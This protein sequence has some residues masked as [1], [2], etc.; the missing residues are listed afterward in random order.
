LQPDPNDR[1][2]SRNTS[3]VILSNNTRNSRNN[4]GSGMALTE[5]EMAFM[6]NHLEGSSDLS[7]DQVSR[8]WKLQL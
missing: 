7:G 2:T 8:L 4:T 5:E 1:I 6:N 3:G